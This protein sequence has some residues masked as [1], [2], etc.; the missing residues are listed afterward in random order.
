MNN[1]TLFNTILS[2]FPHKYIQ[3]AFAYG[4]G[5]FKQTNN[6]DLS[7]NMIDFVF[8][9]N[10]SVQFH[11]EN[12]RLNKSHYSFLKYL[13]PYYISRIQNDFG[14]ACYYNTLVP[15]KLDSADQTCLIKYGVISQ[16]AL[17]QDLYDWDW[18]YMSGRLHKPV[19]IIKKPNI[20]ESLLHENSKARRLQKEKYVDF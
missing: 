11:A 20:I 10:D 3:F 4:S 19:K 15:I 9:V 13:G 1:I 16:E 18:L 6:D 17:I 14:A 8:V 2:R 5:V 7:K 12:I